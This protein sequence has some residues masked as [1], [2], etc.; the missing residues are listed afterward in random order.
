MWIASQL[1]WKYSNGHNTPCT[2]RHILL[3]FAV[4]RIIHSIHYVLITKWLPPWSK[5][6]IT[7]LWI[8]SMFDTLTIGISSMKPWSYKW[9][10]FGLFQQYIYIHIDLEKSLRI[11]ENSKHYNTFTN[12]HLFLY[13]STTK[14][15]AIW[16]MSDHVFYNIIPLRDTK[17]LMF[18]IFRMFR[19]SNEVAWSF[20][21]G[22]ELTLGP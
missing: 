5:G 7:W 21:K 17:Y 18:L 15:Y 4:T 3:W 2:P 10:E 19:C 20:P 14:S 1:L 9:L 13:I 8:K 6:R 12:I 22:T 16:F 11:Y